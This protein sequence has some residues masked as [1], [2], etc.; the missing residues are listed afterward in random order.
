LASL[1]RET[2]ILGLSCKTTRGSALVVG[3]VFR[4]FLWL[5]AVLTLN[6]DASERNYTPKI[7][8]AIEDSKQ[9]T[10]LRAVIASRSLTR[11]RRISIPDLSRRLKLPVIAIT[12]S[13]AADRLRGMKHFHAVV[14]GYHVNIYTAGISG[15]QAEKL[16][17]IGCRKGGRTPEA[18]RVAD[19][20]AQELACRL[21]SR[22]KAK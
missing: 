20:L 18:V 13:K 15:T 5:D 6:L 22:C 1:K 19:L 3:A 14:S 8:R 12:G 4:G 2:R 17:K 16:Y 10:Q 9:Y 7:S 11:D 21:P